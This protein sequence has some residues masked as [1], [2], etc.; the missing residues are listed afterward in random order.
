MNIDQN[1][2]TIT[3]LDVNIFNHVFYDRVLSDYDQRLHSPG[4]SQDT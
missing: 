1:I 4:C 3:H 2:D